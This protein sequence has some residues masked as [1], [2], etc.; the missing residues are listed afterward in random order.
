MS[1]VYP[2]MYI[3]NITELAFDDITPEDPDFPSIQGLSCQIFW[4]IEKVSVIAFVFLLKFICIHQVWL[5]LDLSQASSQDMICSLP[6]MK[7]RV[8]STFLLKGDII[9]FLK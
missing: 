6:W 4:A 2:A 9:N 8:H 1:K 5:N 3:E 7:T